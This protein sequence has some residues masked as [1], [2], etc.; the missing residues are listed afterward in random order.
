MD[1]QTKGAWIVYHTNKL[2]GVTN[3]VNDYDQIN[4]AGKCGLLLSSLASSEESNLT[5]EKVKALAQAVGISIKLEL[6][7]ILKELEKQKLIYCN[8]SGIDILGLSTV[9]TLGYI[10]SIFEDSEPLGREKAVIDLADKT[11]VL[12]CTN[13]SA[14]EYISDTYK[15]GA[16]ETE[17]VLI[18]AEHIGFVDFEEIGNKKKLLFNGNLFR[19]GE[20][21]KINAVCSSLSSA[22]L[23]KVLELND[24]LRSQ[25]CIRLE[26]ACNLMGEDLFKKLHSIGL[27]DV[28][29]V[30][31][32]KG[33]FYFITQPSAFS[34]FSSTIADD[35][36]D[37]AKIFVTSLTYG[38][39]QSSPDRGRI[40]MIRRLMQ[41]LINGE[42]VGPATAIG[43]DYKLLEMRRVIEVKPADLGRFHMKLL[44]KEVGEL[45]LKVIMEGDASTEALPLPSASV[46]SYEGPEQTR[47]YQ[48]KLQEPRLKH[49]VAEILNQLRTGAV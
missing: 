31:N 5:T 9:A 15:L 7:A 37:L 46:I 41:K 4:F 24:T 6:P 2:Q 34:K 28:N 11:S 38:M 36:F 35:A 19:R 40:T 32:E 49:S 30:G 20:A 26:T 16:A 42:L 39:I 10:A 1:R 45:A 43:Q 23:S 18:S 13:I 47:S 25:G 33:N 8:N 21:S 22:E 29:T 14:K 17:E 27:Y 48:R 44:K 3:A 12:P